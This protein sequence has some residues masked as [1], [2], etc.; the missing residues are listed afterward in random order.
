M[1]EI[2]IEEALMSGRLRYLDALGVIKR[3]GWDSFSLDGSAEIVVRAFDRDAH[4]FDSV[5][6]IRESRFELLKQ[7]AKQILGAIAREQRP[8]RDGGEVRLADIRT[9]T[10][11]LRKALE[12]IR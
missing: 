2:V 8:S 7:H 3:K 1:I 4:E 10:E 9:E 6:F 12:E 11:A 5:T